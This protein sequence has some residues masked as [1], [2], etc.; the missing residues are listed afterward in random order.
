MTYLSPNVFATLSIL[1]I[2]YHDSTPG[3]L[4]ILLGKASTLT[5]ST[6][7]RIID[8]LYLS[9]I[10]ERWAYRRFG[11]DRSRVGHWHRFYAIGLLSIDTHHTHRRICIQLLKAPIVNNYSSLVERVLLLNAFGG[12]LL[13]LIEIVQ[14]IGQSGAIRNLESS[15]FVGVTLTKI[16]RF[17]AA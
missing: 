13:I 14:L 5:P 6:E 10:C 15:W 1:T 16:D 11:R 3:T 7:M 2:F 9:C 12:D 17:K 8:S 4:A